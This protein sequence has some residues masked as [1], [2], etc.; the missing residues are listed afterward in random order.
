MLKWTM[1][2]SLTKVTKV[3][4]V[5]QKPA[6]YV[7]LKGIHNK[8]QQEKQETRNIKGSFSVKSW[9]FWFVQL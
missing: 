2:V 3:T 9:I 6:K 5:E 4:K 1:I 7:A 8:I